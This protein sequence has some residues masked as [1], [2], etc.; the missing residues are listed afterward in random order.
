[1]EN[2]HQKNILSFLKGIKNVSTS[3]I[4]SKDFFITHMIETVIFIILLMMYIDNRY[5]IQKKIS[6]IEK[7][8]TELQDLKYEAVTRSSE[9]IGVSR[10]SQVKELILRQG[11][12]LIESDKPAYNLND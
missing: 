11:V 7:L 12:E 10:P 8:K 1:M 4:F 5:T 3:G 9:L 6:E 2:E